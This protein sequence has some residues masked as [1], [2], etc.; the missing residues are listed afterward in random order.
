MTHAPAPAPV[1]ASAPAFADEDVFALTVSGK[2]QLDESETGLSR[3]ELELLVLVDGKAS[4][5]QLA[6]AAP[7]LTPDESRAKLA[8]L[9]AG[10]FIR[11]AKPKEA[12]GYIDFLDFTSPGELSDDVPGTPEDA[13][14]LSSLE[15]AGYYVRIARKAKAPH[16]AAGTRPVALVVDDDPDICTLLKTYLKLEDFDVVVAGN[17]AEV[18]AAFRRQTPFDLVL[19]DVQ[20]PDV[21]GFSI[22][23]KMRQH[24]ALK[25]V[26]VVMLTASATRAAVL[27]GLHYG[28]DGYVTKPFQHDAL[29]KA[30]HSV[31]GIEEIDPVLAGVP[32]A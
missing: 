30:V 21:D 20:L 10:G 31:L 14:R 13:K 1:P 6:R 19:L 12:V 11:T 23:A 5:G 26:P 3:E 15:M 16:R 18:I 25:D 7:G 4:A 28:A 17:R 22:L 27:K 24:P 8:G 2:A 29:M 9:L 32:T